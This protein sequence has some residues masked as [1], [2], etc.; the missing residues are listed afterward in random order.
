[1]GKKSS[2]GI[3]KYRKINAD[4]QNKEVFFFLCFSATEALEV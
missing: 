2:V 3:K 4:L 1:M